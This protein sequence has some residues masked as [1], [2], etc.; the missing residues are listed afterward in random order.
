MDSALC[1]CGAIL[2][3]EPLQVE[4]VTLKTLSLAPQIAPSCWAL[5]Q[6]VRTTTGVG[7]SSQSQG[8]RLSQQSLGW[9]HRG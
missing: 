8:Q 5:L 4:A 1:F 3:S 9:L 7:Y 6:S 2:V